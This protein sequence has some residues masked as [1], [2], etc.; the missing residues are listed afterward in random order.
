MACAG[1]QLEE[2]GRKRERILRNGSVPRAILLSGSGNDIAGDEC[3]M[4]LNHVGS[5]IAGLNEDIVTGV[6][7]KRVKTVHLTII[8]TLA[9]SRHIGSP[10]QFLSSSTA[11]TSPCPTA[12]DSRA[13]GAPAR[14][15][16]EAGIR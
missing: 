5:P 10:R 9:P 4:L 3:G 6:I 2:F 12:A 11:T 8:S 7:D 1:G 13:A 16:I 15:V 14:A